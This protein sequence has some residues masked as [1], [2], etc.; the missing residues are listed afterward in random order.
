MYRS[1]LRAGWVLALVGA[2]AMA[3]QLTS[4]SAGQPQFAKPDVNPQILAFLKPSPIAEGDSD[5]QKKLKERHNVAVKLLEARLNDY[6]RGVRDLSAV[7]DATRLAAD[8][9]LDLAETPEART[10][11][12][13][14][15]LE[16]A[17][18]VESHLEEQLKKGFGSQA[19]LERARFARLSVEVELL[20][21]KR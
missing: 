18:V 4:R 7:F 3:W 17:K 2:V 14:Q 6:K 11:V 5:L 20:K 1:M 19:D 8:A 16:A 9:K 21:N 13:Q 10:A 15:T 12:L